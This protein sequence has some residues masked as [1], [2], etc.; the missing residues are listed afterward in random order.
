[1]KK[2]HTNESLSVYN[3]IFKKNENIYR[4]LAKALGLSECSLWILYILRTDYT[5]PVQ[6]EICAYLHLPKQSI[7]SALKK[8]E[9][10]GY[11][12]L[13]TGND[14][15]SKLVSLTASGI[16]LCEKTVDRLIEVE[17][18]ALEGLTIEE[19]NLFFSLFQKYTDL[20]E[21]YS[22]EIINEA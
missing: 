19:Q 9:S 12:E 8:M 7:N 6:N 3:N 20:M 13:T 17:C 5:E 11:I 2:V 10:D 15:R 18:K 1:M 4:E 16:S 21:V 14:H 22:K